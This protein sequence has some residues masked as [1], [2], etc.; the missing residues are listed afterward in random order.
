[1]SETKLTLTQA[2]RHLG[3][4]KNT[5]L[6]RLRTAGWLHSTGAMRNAPTK[7]ATEQG[8]LHPKLTAYHRG[9]VCIQHPTSLVT[10]KGLVWMQDLLDREAA[11]TASAS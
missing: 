3:I 1:M 4:G 5:L 7:A 6:A 8:L 9:P 2:A 10:A 11:G